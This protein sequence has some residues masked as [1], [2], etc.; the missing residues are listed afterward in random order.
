LLAAA[1]ALGMYLFN[2]FIPIRLCAYHPYPVIG[3]RESILGAVTAIA[4]LA[5]IIIAFRRSRMAFF[6]LLF[7]L[8]NIALVLQIVPVSTF[9]IA[10][11]YN[12]ISSV[13]LCLLVALGVRRAASWPRPAPAVVAILLIA[14]LSLTGWSTFKRC[15]AWKDTLT[16]WSD[17][18]R[19]YPRAVIALQDRGCEYY[20]HGE[21][22]AAD[23]DLSLAL[24]E[25]PRRPE[26][27]LF[28]GATRSKLG[29]APASLADLN[30]AIILNPGN[31]K[32]YLSRGLVLFNQRDFNQATNDFTRAIELSK[33]QSALSFSHRSMVKNA[34]N[35]PE[36]ALQDS[37]TAIKLDPL[38]VSAYVNRAVALEQ[39]GR[40]KAALQVWRQALAMDP[41][42]T[43][44]VQAVTRLKIE[45]G[46]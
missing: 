41:T 1:Y 8:A 30:M 24:Q 34:L 2:F 3:L 28:R 12:Y 26:L 42:C 10:D 23:R 16:I 22:E 27:Y 37:T 11:R 4:L 33:G 6:S 14:T 9:I 46:K 5:L 45:T 17:V 21:Y 44:A 36:G 25:A 43:Q 38:M 29:N 32:A 40:I 13:G 20:A 15:Q 31:Y 19:V 18:L 39:L 7:F 35:D